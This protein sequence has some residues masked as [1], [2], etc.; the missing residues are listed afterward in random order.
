MDDGPVRRLTVD[1]YPRDLPGTYSGARG[2]QDIVLGRLGNLTTR[3]EVE[4]TERDPQAS[5]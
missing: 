5:E 2:L 1:V 4:R 3:C